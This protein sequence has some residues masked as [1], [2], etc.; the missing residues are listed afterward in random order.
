MTDGRKR[1][2]AEP[3]DDRRSR[4]VTVYLDP[5]DYRRLYEITMARGTSMAEALRQIIRETCNDF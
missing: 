4:F 5:A 1:P 3:P 2:R